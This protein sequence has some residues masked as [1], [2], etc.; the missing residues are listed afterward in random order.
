[1]DE[2]EVRVKDLYEIVKQLIDDGM[3]TVTVSIL[4]AD[5]NGGDRIPPSLSFEASTFE[6]PYEGVDYDN[7]YAYEP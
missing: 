7:V 2:I 3:D 6:A 5:D 4:P 1:M